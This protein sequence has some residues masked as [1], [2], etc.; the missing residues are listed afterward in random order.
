MRGD[1]AAAQ[2]SE[3][4]RRAATEFISEAVARAGGLES[5]LREFSNSEVIAEWRKLFAQDGQAAFERRCTLE[6]GAKGTIERYYQSDLGE[7]SERFEW[8]QF[9]NEIAR[10]D[11]CEQSLRDGAPEGASSHPLLEIISP[12]SNKVVSLLL[13]R[14]HEW[15]EINLSRSA[16][17]QLLIS[18]DRSLL[19]IMGAALQAEIASSSRGLGVLG[20]DRRSKQ[21]QELRLSM[22]GAKIPE[23]FLRYPAMGRL[24][25]ERI[26]SW[27]TTL[28]QCL[29]RL[30]IDH[31]IIFARLGIAVNKTLVSIS[32]E[33]SDRHNGGKTV[34]AIGL[35]EGATIL[36]K[37]RDLSLDLQFS[38]LC[39]WMNQRFEADELK[40]PWVI[41][42]GT[43]G[44]V[45]FIKHQVCATDR[46][47]RTFYRRSGVLL[48][49]LDLLDGNDCHLENIIAHGEYPVLIDPETLFHSA[50]RLGRNP[51]Q[52]GSSTEEAA[53]L[54]VGSV[55]R[56]GYLPS[57]HRGPGTDILRDL[58]ALGATQVTISSQPKSELSDLDARG[59]VVL[60]KPSSSPLVD[61][62]LLPDFAPAEV[63]SGFKA[64]RELL[65][66]HQAELL[67]AD[68]PL[69][70][71][72]TLK[73][74]VVIRPTEEYGLV[75]ER[76]LNLDCLR[77]TQRRSLAFELLARK[78]L[79]E[80]IT[81]SW[82]PVFLSER[83]AIE[84]G[85]IP[86][87]LMSIDSTA[88]VLPEG[89]IV[90]DVLEQSAWASVQNRIM[91]L[92]NQQAQKLNH[93]LIN[94]TLVMRTAATLS[95]D[96]PA[97]LQKSQ[98]VPIRIDDVLKIAAT[99]SDNAL[100]LS[101]GSSV[102]MFPECAHHSAMGK[103]HHAITKPDLY[104]GASGI[105]LFFAALSSIT[106]C[107]QHRSIA[108]AGL[109]TLRSYAKHILKTNEP[110]LPGLGG[111][112]GSILYAL[113]AGARFLGD[114]SLFNLAEEL[115][116]LWRRTQPP[117]SADQ[118]DI[119]GGCAG[120][121]L[122][123]LRVYRDG[124]TASMLQEAKALGDF[125]LSSGI[126]TDLGQLAWKGG[127]ARPLCGFAHGAAGIGFALAELFRASGERR[128]QTGARSAFEYEQSMFSPYE[129]G[130]PDFR[131][132]KDGESRSVYPAAWCHGGVGIGLARLGSIDVL[133]RPENLDEIEV[134][135]RQARAHAASGIDQ[136]CC[137]ALSR[138]ELLT[139]AGRALGRH[140][141]INAG[142]AIAMQVVER[143]NRLGGFACLHGAGRTVL[144][145]GLFNG[146]AGI[147]YQL[148]RLLEPQ[149]IPS[150]QLF[151]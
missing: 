31:E 29:E 16:A 130:W 107:E 119:I 95:F 111:G 63:T 18:L 148:L 48:G 28:S 102:W 20:R 67:G 26:F 73:S 35:G 39:A 96:D 41:N 6:I 100:T 146:I 66:A 94:E 52:P 125:L 42:R 32:P 23:I 2:G 9:L 46:E 151:E 22:A 122:A 69:Q 37:P 139:A 25:S 50:L 127:S 80:G 64:C 75:Y 11:E 77:S 106:K 142:E 93:R 43:Y 150:I 137:G 120:D 51:V 17:A 99:L 36:Y 138:V 116:D 124:G 91:A 132:R 13:Q 49:L 5:F 70:P 147:G 21:S 40:V 90:P 30:K 110:V 60:P 71:F 54:F 38:H 65:R 27:V 149:R 61:G 79:P 33:L 123:L 8:T 140:E 143:A 109:G 59:D 92:N 81:D 85:D 56:L 53:K 55:A 72:K 62:E 135:A 113:S 76:S 7:H 14:N 19:E 104:E 47:L 74:R 103:Y 133:E 128:Y 34:V 87:F 131:D 88:L 112:R 10:C 84:R 126:K 105:G 78:L 12:F 129:G 141:L 98:L 136:L 86:H 101:D 115:F 117:Q 24:V 68:S 83:K 82:F 144:V 1:V 15:K 145:P 57:W 118:F 58:S 97:P 89:V 121:L 44:W 114:E 45:E 3:E 108:L 134:A 4:I